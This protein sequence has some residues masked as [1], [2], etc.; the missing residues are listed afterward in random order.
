MLGNCS[1]PTDSTRYMYGHGYGTMFLA[2]VYGEEEDKDQRKKLETVLTRAVEFIAKAQTN[3][4]HRKP[5]GKEV[6][7]G[8]WGYVSAADGNNFDEGSVT[9]TAVQALRAARNAGIK[10]PKETIDKADHLPRSLHDARRRHHLQLHGRPGARQRRQR[11]A[12][13]R[14]PR[15]RPLHRHVHQRRRHHDR[16]EPAEGRERPSVVSGSR[17]ARRT[18]R[19]AKG[20]IGHDEYQSYYFA[21]VV[22]V[23][24]DDRYGELFPGEAKDTHLTW[25]QVQ[26]RRCSRT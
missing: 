2:S 14:G 8:G 9:I 12:H 17:T 11:R 15:L 10:V 7:I 16:A 21:Q 6:D 26:G 1:S 5:E 13:R 3:K 18:S 20:R 22:Y 23:L 4:K 24:G 19:S 25:T